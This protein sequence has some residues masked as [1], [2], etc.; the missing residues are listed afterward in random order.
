MQGVL[1][2]FKT[3]FERNGGLAFLNGL[4]VE[5]LHAAALQADKVIVVPTLVEFKNRFVGFEMM[6]YQQAG[7]FKLCE[8]SIDRGEAGI[9]ALFQQQAVDVLC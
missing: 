4:V 1:A 6:A 3:A 9:R 8:Y 2:D 5:L 7:L